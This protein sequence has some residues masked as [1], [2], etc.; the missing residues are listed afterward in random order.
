MAASCIF[1]KH[2]LLEDSAFLFFVSI[3]AIKTWSI[4]I[5]NNM[6]YDLLDVSN[7][8]NRWIRIGESEGVYG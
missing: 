2:C 3:L 8:L 1:S 4:I 7:N 5:L 6:K